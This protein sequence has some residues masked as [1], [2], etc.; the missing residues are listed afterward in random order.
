MFFL[1]WFY[2]G[3]MTSVRNSHT[4]S[5]L[6]DETVLVAGEFDSFCGTLRTAELY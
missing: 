2:T 4:A 1:G 3:S 5:I 6:T